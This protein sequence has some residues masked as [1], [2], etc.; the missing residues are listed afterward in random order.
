MTEFIHDAGVDRVRATRVPVF[1][2]G[3]E[4]DVALSGQDHRHRVRVVFVQVLVAMTTLD[5]RPRYRVVA[6]EVD[7]DDVTAAD[8]DAVLRIER[9][10]AVTDPQ[11]H[12]HRLTD[13]TV[14]AASPVHNTHCTVYDQASG[15]LRELTGPGAP[16][17]YGPKN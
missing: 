6:R 8:G 14:P 1:A 2:A 10:V 5:R 15:G 16:D 12:D 3:V 13:K 17:I 7:T 4:H 11:R 9:E